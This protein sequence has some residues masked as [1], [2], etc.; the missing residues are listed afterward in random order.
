MIQVLPLCGIPIRPWTNEFWAQAKIMLDAHDNL[1]K[2]RLKLRDPA[3][4]IFSWRHQANKLEAPQVLKAM[5]YLC[6]EFGPKYEESQFSAVY[7]SRLLQAATQTLNPQRS[8]QA[9]A[10]SSPRADS[11]SRHYGSAG[12]GTEDQSELYPRIVPRSGA[13][14]LLPVAA[15]HPPGGL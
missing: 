15:Q 1:R 8:N 3:R 6:S 4:A 2:L 7:S 11:G 13:A 5:A 10:D 12:R 9:H 14:D